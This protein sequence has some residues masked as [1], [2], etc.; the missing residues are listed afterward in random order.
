MA[1][2]DDG[3]ERT[4]DATPRRREQARERGEVPRSKELATTAL[5][6]GAAGTFMVLTPWMADK[7]MELAKHAWQLDAA[8]VRAPDAMFRVLREGTY[9]GVLAAA[10]VLIVLAIAAIVAGVALGG[11]AFTFEPLLPQLSRIDPMAGLARM[12][13]KRAV[14]ELAKATLKLMVVGGPIVMMLASLANKMLALDRLNIQAAIAHAVGLIGWGFL[15]MAAA[16]AIVA[17]VDVPWQLYDFAEK[18]KMSFQEIKEESKDSDGRPEVK[19]RIRRLQ[20]DMARKRMLTEVPNADVIITN[21][22][23]YAVALKYDQNTMAAPQVLAKGVDLL[24]ERIR[25]VAA[26][27]SITVIQTPALARAVYYSTEV[28]REVPK[29]LYLAVARVL[30]YVMQL[31]RYRT[32]IG[33]APVWPDELPIPDELKRD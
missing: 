1:G 13:S 19:S 8:T 32:G 3:Q 12:F 25:H 5:L 22:E 2:Q 17:L 4:E 14:V 6:L 10:P 27:H 23:H 33:K 31:N 16:T 15:A 18:L 9:I 29:G 30:A 28:G 20:Q 7:F 11:V 24:A 21:P 26:E